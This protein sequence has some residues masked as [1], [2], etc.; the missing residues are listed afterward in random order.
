MRVTKELQFFLQARLSD[1]REKIYRPF[2]YLAVHL[3]PTDPAQ[4]TL[5]PY[6]HRCID[7]CM[8][9]LRRGTPRHRH[10]GTWYE[11]RGMFLKSLLLVAVAKSGRVQ[12]PPSWQD[13]PDLCMAGFKFWEQEAPDLQEARD[14][15]G[16]FLSEV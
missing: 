11:N 7:A 9:F 15:L 5:A 10:H 2:L 13:G 6:V 4:H 8:T 16:T 12:L 1:F 3:P 14:V